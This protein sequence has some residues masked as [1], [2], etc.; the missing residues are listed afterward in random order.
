MSISSEKTPSGSYVYIKLRIDKD[1]AGTT[2][3]SP[4]PI[5]TD[6]RD[7]NVLAAIYPL[8]VESA[9]IRTLAGT[10]VSIGD[11]FLLTA[12]HLKFAIQ[13]LYNQSS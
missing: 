13:C 3:E 12:R 7:V 8:L 11:G 9:G 10:V 4:F 2:A 5:Q 6:N 1:C